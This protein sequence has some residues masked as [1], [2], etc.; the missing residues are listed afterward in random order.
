MPQKLVHYAELLGQIKQRI[1]QGQTL[2]VMSANAEMIL[3]YWDIGRMILERQE[4]EGWGASVLPRLSRDLHNEMPEVKGFSERN[5]GYMIRFA[6]EYD[7]SPILQQTVAKLQ[8]PENND[9]VK[10]T[11]PVA[12]ISS[13]GAQPIVQQLVAKK[14]LGAPH[15]FHGKGQRPADPSLG[16]PCFIKSKSPLSPFAKGGVKGQIEWTRA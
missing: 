6:R 7:A 4:R 9:D 12:K 13:D 14:L 8:M 1:R 15:P 11:Q 5:I 2:A 10:V 16:S 3:T